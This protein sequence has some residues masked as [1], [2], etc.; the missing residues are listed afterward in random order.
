MIFLPPFP[1]VATVA[2][3]GEAASMGCF[4]MFMGT[5]STLLAGTVETLEQKLVR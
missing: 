5:V 2:S 4:L 3:A 1:N